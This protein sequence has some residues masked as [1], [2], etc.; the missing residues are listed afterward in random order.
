VPGGSYTFSVRATNAA[1]TSGP[2]N[3]GTLTFPGPCLGP[4][5]P[6]SNFLAYNVG[7]TV[8]VLWDPAPTGPA[9]TSYVLNVSGAFVEDFPTTSRALSG[10]A[11]AGTYNLRLTSVNPCG[12]STTAIQ[13]VVVP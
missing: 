12:S 2:S 13:T 6:S 4:P 10:I 3:F 5:L 7:N 1:G 11:P 8:R 9:T